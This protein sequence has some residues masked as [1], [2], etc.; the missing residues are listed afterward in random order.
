MGD[1]LPSAKQKQVGS[2]RPCRG[3][4]QEVDRLLTTVLALRRNRK[5]IP[6]G[7]YRFRSFE[8]ATEWSIRMM[9]RR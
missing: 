2:R 8:E 7:V 3:G 6:R 1:S 9:A 4:L 5:F